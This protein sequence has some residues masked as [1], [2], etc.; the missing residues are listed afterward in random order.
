MCS[1]LCNWHSDPCLINYTHFTT[2]NLFSIQR[3]LPMQVVCCYPLL[4]PLT[5][6]FACS[7]ESF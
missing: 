2:N 6:S 4:L 7:L 5:D 1:K 3:S